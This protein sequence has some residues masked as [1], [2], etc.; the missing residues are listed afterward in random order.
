MLKNWKPKLSKFSTFLLALI[1][2]LQFAGIG[3]FQ[4]LWQKMTAHYWFLVAA[5]VFSG[6][7]AL[8]IRYWYISTRS[9]P[10]NIQQKIREWLDTFNISHRVVPWEPWHF[11]YDVTFWNQIIF[12]GR[13]RNGGRYL[14]IELRTTG[15][16]Q[17][18]EEAFKSLTSHQKLKFECSIALE[19]ARARVSF[20]RHKPDYS[21]VSITT[22]LPITPKLS[23]TDFLNGLTEVLQGGVIVWNAIALQLE[24][25][26]EI[27]L[28]SLTHDTEASPPKPT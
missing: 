11:R 2:Y 19:T 24:Q 17:Q 20:N 1:A 4:T 28:P 3:D 18:Y 13:P 5:F 22:I 21:D 15:V 25:S 14:H 6:F 12:V 23:A 16:V 9:T 8:S 27:K 26:P 10:A 7:F